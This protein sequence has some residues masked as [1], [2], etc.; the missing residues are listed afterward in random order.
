[1]RVVDVARP[2]EES[3][4]V[5]WST[6]RCQ[7]CLQVWPCFIGRV[8]LH[9]FFLGAPKTLRAYLDERLVEGIAVRPGDVELLRA[10]LFDW[11]I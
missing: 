5:D 3:H 11:L 4:P 8:L 9:A 6:G 10:Q 2:V 1:M 7:T